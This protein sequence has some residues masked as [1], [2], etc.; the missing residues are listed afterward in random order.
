MF[1]LNDLQ[2]LKLFT[3]TKQSEP[4]HIEGR[5]TP[6]H[7]VGELLTTKPPAGFPLFWHSAR[8]RWSAPGLPY[9]G[10]IVTAFLT[11]VVIRGGR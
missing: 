1:I 9:S 10:N 5:K 4:E 8:C 7:R 3:G 6:M 2:Y 11:D